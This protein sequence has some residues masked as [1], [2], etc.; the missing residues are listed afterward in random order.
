MTSRRIRPTALVVVLALGVVPFGACAPRYA[1][2]P[3]RLDATVADSVVTS[4]VAAGARLHRIVN[5]RA[6][7]RAYVLDVDLACTTLHAMKGGPSAVGRTTTS[8]L[9]ASLP[10]NSGAIATL[11]ADFFSFTPPGVPTNLHVERGV[12]LAGPGGKPVFAVQSGRPRIDSVRVQG[13]I[14][15]GASTMAIMAWNRP[16]AARVGVVDAKWGVPLDTLLRRHVLRLDPLQGNPAHVGE[17]PAQ[18]RGRFV[19]RAAR[20]A[21]TLVQGDTLLLHLPQRTRVRIPPRGPADTLALHDGDTVQ[22]HVELTSRDRSVAITEAVGG[23]PIVLADSVVT[24]DVDTEGNDG[25]RGLNPRSVMGLDRAGRRAWL[26]VIDGRQPGYSAG[27]TLRQ[28]GAFM[29]ALGATHALNLDGGGSSALA[30]REQ[31]R[32]AVDAPT[33]VQDRVVNRPSDPLERPVGNGL[34][35]FSLCS[36]R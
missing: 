7:W 19:V 33:R 11:N 1:M 12:L 36:S 27:M 3:L 30:V 9:L 22:V 23:R 21:D 20:A 2:A 24:P 14:R 34:A 29:Q 8:G 13:Q 17:Q 26:A 25:F 5:L 15:R 10:A 18:V 16:V 31:R 4:T 35:V 32:S 6:P 28:V